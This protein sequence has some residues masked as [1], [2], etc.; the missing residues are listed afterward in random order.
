MG[1]RGRLKKQGD[2]EGR[3]GMEMGIMI[4]HSW[5]IAAQALLAEGGCLGHLKTRISRTLK[6]T[7]HVNRF[8]IT[9]HL[10]Q[11][12]A[13]LGVEKRPVIALCPRYL[14]LSRLACSLRVIVG[15]LCEGQVQVG[16]ENDWRPT[17]SDLS[18]G[19][20]F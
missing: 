14:L 3:D 16:S 4:S 11:A 13:C 2:V 7:S 12:G 5:C 8:Y 15:A 9:T 18:M 6:W 19:Q 20:S 10:L 17:A 1:E